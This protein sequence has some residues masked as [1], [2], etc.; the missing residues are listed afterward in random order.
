MDIS[1]ETTDPK[2]H[3]LP[4][5]ITDKTVAIVIAH[6]FGKWCDIDPVI[7]VAEK[8]GL[9]VI[10]DCAESFCGFHNLGNPR[11]QLSLFSFGIIKYFTAFGGA[12]VK[13]KS[14]ETY[15]KM[16]AIYESYPSAGR[17]EYLKKVCKIYLANVIMGSP[18]LTHSLMYL[19]RLVGFDYKSLFINM[20]RGFPD[21]MLRR[22]KARPSTPL[23][24]TLRERLKGFSEAEYD[25]CQVKAEYVRTRLPEEAQLVG[26]KAKVNNYWLFPILVVSKLSSSFITFFVYIVLLKRRLF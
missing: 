13:V 21:E 18:F 8:Y 19:G 3:I 24:V 12:V 22:I 10:E 7:D 26:M 14:D 1:I 9:P 6:I 4:S 23:L 16:L 11:A 2:L 15:R 20:L 5:L 17:T 25:V